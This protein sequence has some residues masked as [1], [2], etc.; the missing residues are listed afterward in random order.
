MRR[1]HLLELKKF[2]GIKEKD[3][4]EGEYTAVANSRQVVVDPFPSAEVEEGE[5]PE[6]PEIKF[7]LDG[8]EYDCE[9][10]VD[11]A[12]RYYTFT[13]KDLPY[14]DASDK[15]LYR[16]YVTE[17]TV[18]GFWDP[19]YGFMDNDG[20]LHTIPNGSK[21]EDG[22][23]IINNIAGVALPNTGGPGTRLF[24]ILGSILILGA[25][26]LLWRRRRLI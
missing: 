24:T 5:E 13:I 25:G 16:Y 19:L 17:E 3:N 8:V 26:V 18:D 21:A 10:S 11:D 15:K 7:T 12:G 1:T 9:V 23:Y 2:F 6:R 22:Q 14:R 4:G 20:E